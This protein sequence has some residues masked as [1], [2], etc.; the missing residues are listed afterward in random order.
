MEANAK[1]ERLPSAVRSDLF[2]GLAQD[3]FL[4]N[5]LGYLQVVTRRLRAATCRSLS[6]SISL[7]GLATHPPLGN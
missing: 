6:F 4:K 2:V 1:A 5:Q 3:F 7:S